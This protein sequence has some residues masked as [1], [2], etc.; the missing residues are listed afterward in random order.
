QQL[1]GGFL[2]S[3]RPAL[4]HR[5]D[6][7]WL[8]RHAGRRRPD[9]DLARDSP[10]R[11]ILGGLLPCRLAARGTDI[12]LAGVPRTRLPGPGGRLA[13]VARRLPVLA[14]DGLLRRFRE[15]RQTGHRS[16]L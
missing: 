13:A 8:L 5:L 16:A 10:Y 15:Y 7:P 12:A 14:A 2:P 6:Q 11:G 3:S 9:L 4:G 1:R